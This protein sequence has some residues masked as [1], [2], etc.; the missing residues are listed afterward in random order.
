MSLC[1]ARAVP[2][3]LEGIS[4]AV[5]LAEQQQL[6]A[7]AHLGALPVGLRLEQVV[8]VHAV[9]VGDD[10]AVLL[11]AEDLFLQ[12]DALRPA[13]VCDVTCVTV[14]WYAIAPP[15]SCGARSMSSPRYFPT[16]NGFRFP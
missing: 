7:V 14:T 4:L 9:V 11:W 5:V 2:A 15:T 6:E 8:P 10:L 3:V 16:T 12:E 1:L 13:V